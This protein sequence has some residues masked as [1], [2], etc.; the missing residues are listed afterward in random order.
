[1][2]SIYQQ[3]EKLTAKFGVER[4]CKALEI[5]KSA[6]YRRKINPGSRVKSNDILLDRIK[7]IHEKCKQRFGSPQMT[8]K[9]KEEGYN[10]NHKRVEKLMKKHNIRP[11]TKKKYKITTDSNHKLAVCPN[12]VNRDF[13]PGSINKLW[14][15]DITYIKTKEEW[16]YLAVVIDLFSRKVVGWSMSKHM[17]RQLVIDSFMMAWEQRGKPQ[18]LIYHSDR[19]SQYASNDFQKLLK[20]CNVRQSMSRKANC[21]DNACAES[22]FASLKKEEVYREEYVTRSQ[23]RSCIFEY[24]ELFYNSY[25]PHSYAEGLSP[26]EYEKKKS[27]VKVA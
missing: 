11:K 14:C 22:F 4:I 25:R 21:W 7:L 6:Y 26:N 19:G 5:Q 1:M 20:K 18:N 15:S 8:K 13:S 24:I 2:D 27:N 3:V 12:L 23:A 10:C 9:L 17:S 16:L